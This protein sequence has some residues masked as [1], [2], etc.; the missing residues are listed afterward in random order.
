MK[1][2]IALLLVGSSAFAGGWEKEVCTDF[3]VLVYATRGPGSITSQVLSYCT[4]DEAQNKLAEIAQHPFVKL[5]KNG[6]IQQVA[7]P[8]LAN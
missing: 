6:F 4:I 8:L 7:Q 5:P 3:Q 1:L 2:F